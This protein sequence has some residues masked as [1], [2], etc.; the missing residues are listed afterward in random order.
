MNLPDIIALLRQEIGLNPESIGEGA[1]WQAVQQ[2]LAAT[3]CRDLAEYGVRLAS[4]YDEVQELVEQVTVAETWFFREESAFECLRQQAQWRLLNAPL[5]RPFQ[6]ASLPCSTG[7][8][9]YSIAMALLDL[10][11]PAERFR[12]HAL[13]VSYRVLLRAQQAVYGDYAFRS[14][15]KR[16]RAQ[17]FEV[18][19]TGY[20]L[21]QTVR[22]QVSFYQGNVLA[23]PPAFASA[24]YDVV[25][26]RNLLIYL[27]PQARKRMVTELKRILSPTGILLVGHAE[28]GMLLQAGF[29]RR[30]DGALLQANAEQ[31]QAGSLPATRGGRRALPVSDA[32]RPAKKRPGCRDLPFAK[33]KP[34]ALEASSQTTLTAVS[35]NALAA[36]ETN[37]IR[38]LAN[39]GQLEAARL[40]GEKQLAQGQRSADLYCVMGLIVRAQGHALAAR[41]CYRKA[42]YLD[43]QHEEAGLQLAMLLEQAGETGRAKSLRQRVSQTSQMH[44]GVDGR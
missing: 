35:P 3:A 20:R 22:D 40:R 19:P 14:A 28:V 37:A 21:A 26:S 4:S 34:G 2:R 6:V 33:D 23:L 7:E 42:L 18:T 11:L 12:V 32:T 25:F 29:V 13:D 43:P 9:P 39:A 8:E 24:S 31:A 27:D 17:Y 5:A 16:F 41:D 15:D 38:A 1:V 30:V 36:N 44:G 10:G